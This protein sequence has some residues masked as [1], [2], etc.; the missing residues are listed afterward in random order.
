[1]KSNDC[2]Y[3]YTSSAWENQSPQ[4]APSML[5]LINSKREQ[6]H[7]K[8]QPHPGYP[9]IVNHRSTSGVQ[10]DL[11]ADPNLPVL[12]HESQHSEAYTRGC[13]ERKAPRVY[14]C[15]RRGRPLICWRAELSIQMS[16]GRLGKTARARLIW[17]RPGLGWG[18]APRRGRASLAVNLSF[19]EF[20]RLLRARAGVDMATR[21]ANLV[22][23]CTFSGGG[24]I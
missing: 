10:E 7:E 21:R 11:D 6:T 16:P 23:S 13:G 9:I 24:K 8:F 5:T 22:D 4:I 12:V 17:V 14:I 2:M 3:P 19:G 18:R 15:E 1:M 20:D